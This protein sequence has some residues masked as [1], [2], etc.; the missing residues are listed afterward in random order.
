MGE[1][2][3]RAPGPHGSA[4]KHLNEASY[5]P[6]VDLGATIYIRT[7]G[8]ADRHGLD[9]H[10]SLFEA[11]PQA[12]WPNNPA[13]VR[14]AKQAILAGIAEKVQPFSLR[15]RKRCLVVAKNV[16]EASVQLV[17]FVLRPKINRRALSNRHPQ[18]SPA[19][20]VCD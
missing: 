14:Y 16:R 3:N 5:L 18:P 2:A 20:N 12:G 19:K 10:G 7:S 17:L 9:V 11:G 1:N 6:A 13:L 8:D 15:L 4:L